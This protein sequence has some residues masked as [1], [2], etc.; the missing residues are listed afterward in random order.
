MLNLNSSILLV[1][2]MVLVAS[3]DNNHRKTAVN[4]E[5]INYYIKQYED[6]IEMD[7]VFE[8]SEEDRFE[9]A[10]KYLKSSYENDELIDT[11]YI[12]QSD[13][14]HIKLRYFCLKNQE[15]RIPYNYYVSFLNDDFVTH[16]FSID[17]V[18]LK[19]KEVYFNERYLKESFFNQLE[20]YELKKYG[21]FFS[22]YLELNH[23]MFILSV[24]IS[25]P[26]TDVGELV[27]D[28]IP[29]FK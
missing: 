17:L 20:N 5:S 23:E 26:L 12:I 19:N 9:T 14:F 10:L 22:P 1:V 3:C 2:F 4:H 16:D 8:P 24:S 25:I 27:S 15:L 21:I 13:T 6:S 29:V 18:V 28:T 11:V 7:D